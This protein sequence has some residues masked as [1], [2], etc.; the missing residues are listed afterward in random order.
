MMGARWLG[1]DSDST[2]RA[3]SRSMSECSRSRQ[4]DHLYE[5]CQKNKLTL[6]C[7]YAQSLSLSTMISLHRMNGHASYS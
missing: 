2:A 3:T 7:F 5:G 6:E 4:E 1:I